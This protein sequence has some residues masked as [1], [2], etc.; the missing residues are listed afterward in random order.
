MKEIASSIMEDA[1]A[2][3][4]LT[5]GS[6]PAADKKCQDHEGINIK[7]FDEIA[8]N[9]SSSVYGREDKGPYQSI[10]GSCSKLVTVVNKICLAIQEGEYDGKANVDPK[11]VNPVSKRA[12]KVKAEIC[13]ME[14]LG[15]KL[16]AKDTDI[17]E[18]RKHLK[19]KQEELSEGNVRLGLVEKKL[20]NASREADDR[21]EKVQKRLQ[22]LQ[23]VSKKKEREFDETL[24]HMQGDIDALEREK[25]E[26]K[27][28]LN[29]LSKK[30]LLEGLSR[31]QGQPSGI[32][33]VV[34][35]TASAPGMSGGQGTQVVIQDS[36][37]LVEQLDVLRNAVRHLKRENTRLRSSQTKAVFTLDPLIL[38]KKPTG[39]ASPT[40][41]VELDSETAQPSQLLSLVRRTNQVQ[42]ELEDVCACPSVVDI[43]RRK[44][45]QL[46]AVT[47]ATPKNQLLN[48]I[49][50]VHDLNNYVTQLQNE[51]RRYATRQRPG[52][53]AKSDFSEFNSNTYTKAAHERLSTSVCIGKIR[54]PVGK[55]EE[56]KVVAL[57]LQ[58]QHLKEIH[59]H[60]R[61]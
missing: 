38:P 12:S 7:K 34:A 14:G 24:D 17:K 54:V 18:L 48:N 37:M 46:P 44:P 51:I 21:V 31:S 47:T 45:G 52:A 10:R 50:K 33:A 8:C 15:L 11:H 13:D 53:Q 28:R 58:P 60:F 4:D 22:E 25:S 20:E 40:G 59:E 41:F 19:L 29:T 2:L 5:S 30:T 23:Q 57:N 49:T 61:L 35:G 6:S 1:S 55:G 3:Q 42:K 39:L 36:P 26:L 56:P 16:E 43:T 32:A 9:A 27:T